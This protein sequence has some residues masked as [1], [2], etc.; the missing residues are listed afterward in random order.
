M[1]QLTAARLALVKEPQV[2][3]VGDTVTVQTA[4]QAEMEAK[5]AKRT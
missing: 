5:L 4:S 1:G 3:L 2:P